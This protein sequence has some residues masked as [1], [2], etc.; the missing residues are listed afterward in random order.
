MFNQKRLSVPVAIIAV[1]AMAGVATAGTINSFISW[2]PDTVVFGSDENA[3]ELI[4]A[5]GGEDTIIEI[6]DSL[7]GIMVIEQMNLFRGGVPSEIDLLHAVGNSEF[8]AEFQIMV[9][10]KIPTGNP[11]VPFEFWF[12]PDPAFD[13][14]GVGTMVRMYED[15]E[16]PNDVT[17]FDIH[18]FTHTVGETP[19]IDIP[20]AVA[21]VTD[22]VLFWAL[23]IVPGK[24]NAWIGFGGDDIALSGSPTNRFSDAIFA[25]NRTADTGAAAGSI[26]T[27]VTMSNM[28]GTGE[29]IG[30]SEIGG[31]I[32]GSPW[33]LSS[34]TN[35]EMIIIPLP[36]AVWA[37][38]GL[39]GLIG[40]FSRRRR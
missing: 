10:N 9:V 37:G 24:G 33:P 28:A 5:G 14:N 22:G 25:L 32:L 13:T 39:F 38:M 11:L 12:A 4:N 29:V 30:T 15:F 26:H 36:A 3:E 31:R 21:S 23:G 27:M 40:V 19:G 35:V 1:L 2:P 20:D 17:D 6:G 34:N 18:D 8:T 7:H 16:A